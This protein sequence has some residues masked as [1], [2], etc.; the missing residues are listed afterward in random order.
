MNMTTPAHILKQ[1]YI[2]KKVA[3]AE[4][5]KKREKNAK[6]TYLARIF[7]QCAWCVQILMELTVS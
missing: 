2:S 5:I 7:R 3:S 4:K 1:I 6:I